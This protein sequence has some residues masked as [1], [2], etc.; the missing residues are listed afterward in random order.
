[1]LELFEIKAK[2]L[3]ARD[4]IRELGDSLWQRKLTKANRKQWKNH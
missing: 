3:Q 1:M 4:T 2:V